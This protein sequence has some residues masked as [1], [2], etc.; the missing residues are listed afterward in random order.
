[1]DAT[2]L[3]TGTIYKEDDAPFLVVKYEH[4]KTAR[5][6]ATVKVKVRNLIT[7][8][9]LQK[10]YSHTSRVEDAD[11][12]TRKSQYLYKDGNEYMFMDPITFSQFGIT[13]DIVRDASKFITEGENVL[14]KFF[15]DAPI[16][17]DLPNSM[18]FEVTY[19][20]PGY[21]GNTVTNTFKDATI[22]TGAV[23]K[24]PTFIKIGDRVKIDTRSGTYISKA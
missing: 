3:K 4:V 11:V 20:E 23:V 8:Q 10:S 15:E 2:A 5:G 6:G 16:S 7:G 17:I 14:V 24:V 18:V 9:V 19:T 13:E 21:K 22:S 1:M 12:A